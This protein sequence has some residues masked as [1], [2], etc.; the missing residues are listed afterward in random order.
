MISDYDLEVICQKVLAA[1][2][3]RFTIVLHKHGKSV[4]GH[5]VG[6]VSMMVPKSE[7]SKDLLLRANQMLAKLLDTPS[8]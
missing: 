8:N 2:E 1:D 7:L 5:L 3:N 6:K 4:L